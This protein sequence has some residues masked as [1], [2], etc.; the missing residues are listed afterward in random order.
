MSYLILPSVEDAEARSQA[1]YAPLRP[2]TEAEAAIT[3]GVWGYVLH[4]SDGRASLVV[5]PTPIEAGLGL[6]QAAYDALLTAGERAAL[7]EA[8]PADWTV[9]IG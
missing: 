8:L 6:S 1:A 2:L 9:P 4:P 3:A 7:I 5:P